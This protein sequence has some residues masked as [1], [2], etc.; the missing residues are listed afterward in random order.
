MISPLTWL[1]P[2]PDINTPRS[3]PPNPHLPS[4]QTQ[5]PLL[6][7]LEQ[8]FAYGS[9]LI[10]LPK[11]SVPLHHTF[12]IIFQNVLYFDTE[13]VLG[14]LR[15]PEWSLQPFF[16]PL[17]NAHE[18]PPFDPLSNQTKPH[19]I[20]TQL[21]IVIQPIQSHRRIPVFQCAYTWT[22]F[23]NTNRR[24]KNACLITTIERLNIWLTSTFKE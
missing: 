21:S 4:T 12:V 10:W 1:S 22:I 11:A 15:N 16:N 9:F 6:S 7:H 2:S 17:R 13:T 5:I 8:H 14:V 20:P 19:T 23:S 24:E 3:S 18:H